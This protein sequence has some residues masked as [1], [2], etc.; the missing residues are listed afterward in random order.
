MR[1]PP[2][3]SHT[4]TKH[5]ILPHPR[6]APATSYRLLITCGVLCC[7]LIAAA[8]LRLPTHNANATTL[9]PVGAA[10]PSSFDPFHNTFTPL[11][12]PAPFHDATPPGVP[13]LYGSNLAWGDYDND[14]LLDFVLIG[15]PFSDPLVRLYHNDGDGAFH[16]ATPLNWPGVFRGEAVW[17][18]YDN[19]GLLDLLYIGY[20]GSP[21]DVTKLY[22]NDGN[23]AFHDATP[24]GVP[25][26]MD[27]MAAWADYD[28]DGLLDFVVA[29]FHL[30]P[31]S[32]DMIHLYHNDGDGAFHDATPPVFTPIGI[33]SIAWGDYDNDGRPDLLITGEAPTAIVLRL[34]HNDGDGAFH[35]TTPPVLP[36]F[37]PDYATVAWGDY[38][39]D[40]LLD[41]VLAGVPPI[42]NATSRLYH[43][44]GGGTFHEV[45]QANLPGLAIGDA[46]WGDFDNDG[47]IDL[48]IVGDD[49]HF[50]RYS[51]LY[52]NDGGGL[53]SDVTP[54][55]WSAVD[56]GGIDWGDYDNDGRLD[57]LLTGQ[58]DSATY[59][60]RLYH[61]DATLANTPPGAPGNLSTSEIDTNSVRLSWSAATDPQTPSSGLSYNLR[62]G[63]SPG[64]SDIVGPMANTTVITE[65]DGLRRLPALGRARP[66]LTTTLN[67][68]LPGQ[69]Y[70]WSV[71]SIDPALAGGPFA[72][73][74]QFTITGGSPTPTGTIAPTAT[75]TGTPTPTHSA[76]NT[77]TN[78][79]ANTV[80]V[81]AIPT[82]TNT[83]TDTP[84]STPIITATPPATATGTSTST[85][86][87]ASTPPAIPTSTPSAT[88]TSTSTPCVIAFTD[89]QPTDYFYEPVRSLYCSG[90][91]SGYPD[92]T[93]RPYNNASRGQ[94]T[95]IVVLAQA[96]SINTD[97][98]P[99]FSDVSLS[100]PFYDY[101]ETAFNAHII[102]GY[103]DG[104]F[105]WSNN[106]TR[107]QL[108]KI[109][110]NTRGWT[111]N[112]NGG[113]HFPDVPQGST[114]YDFIETAYNHAIISGYPDG[115]F[116]PANPATRGQIAKIVY[117]A[118]SGP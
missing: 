81:T 59:V 94:L 114:F 4:G 20:S 5:L 78:T 84:T 70:Y 61:N 10:V 104:T 29:G 101:I 6:R 60:T 13:G 9:K 26:A 64:A 43:N 28:N 39:N 89:V 49:T 79:P 111:I 86:T 115:S 103:D 7:L 3:T 91:I 92:N 93:F 32:S 37:I 36:T 75:R 83:P 71:Q 62:V 14:G 12:D 1:Y 38:D 112:T 67:S 16:D 90:A 116:G 117:L 33:G 110:V 82:N 80:T 35:D 99:H 63:T 76:T 25:G 97:G 109:V 98:G 24:P 30:S 8:L 95:K 73:E 40:G 55:G 41:F 31:S 46:D 27:G 105:R 23:G 22:H 65:P 102:S 58:A 85:N 53:F 11:R 74:S 56:T 17:G 42:G 100:N 15:S 50:M 54:T 118:T 108:T 44:D 48:A 96:M 66:N 19:D 34:Y 21:S 87:P 106:I 77:P 88:P 57:L 69:T 47:L 51:K 45:T 2:A 72:T 68:L 107:G 18:D 113:P 52:H